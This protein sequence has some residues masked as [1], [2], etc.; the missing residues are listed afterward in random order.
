MVSCQEIF[1]LTKPEPYANNPAM[2]TAEHPIRTWRRR[3]K[4][5]QR[6]LCAAVGCSETHLSEIEA[7]RRGVSIRLAMRIVE[8]TGL[9]LNEVLANYQR[10]AE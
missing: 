7:G 1:R 10:A 3:N 2:T 5:T 9:S 8:K 4:F 6:D